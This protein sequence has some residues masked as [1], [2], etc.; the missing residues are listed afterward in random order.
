[1]QQKFFEIID[2]GRLPLEA[3][4]TVL[5][6]PGSTLMRSPQSEAFIDARWQE[7]LNSGNKPWPNDLKPT[8][9]RLAKLTR[10]GDKLEVVLDQ[11]ISYRDSLGST[12]EF[13]KLFG[14]SFVPSALALSVVIETADKQVLVTIRNDK[15]DY[16]PLGFHVSTGGYFDIRKDK[17]PMDAGKREACEETGVSPEELK[18]H[19]MGTVYNPWVTHPDMVFLARTALTAKEILA[20]KHDDENTIGFIPATADDLGRLM[21]AYTHANVVVP[22]AGLLMYGGPIFGNA[23]RE[24]LLD[25]L[26][27]TSVEY[28]LEE[29]RKDL[30]T[31]DTAAFQTAIKNGYLRPT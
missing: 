31:R 25:Y 5:I 2:E 22:M 23:W 17:T 14:R 19:Y 6:E 8:R 27:H 3:I 11:S 26:A 12:P 30:E 4:E 15:T 9:A 28:E 16:K 29:V 20:R 10:A 1:M 24:G 7:H 18:M 21:V 13:E